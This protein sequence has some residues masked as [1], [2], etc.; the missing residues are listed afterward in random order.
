ML[1]LL[2]RNDFVKI[3]YI[4]NKQMADTYIWK[5][6]TLDR[7]ILN[8]TVYTIHYTVSASRTNPAEGESDYTADSYGTVGVTADPASKSFI[9]YEHLTEDIC[10]GWVKADLGSESVDNIEARISS[11][12]DE[13]I[14]PINAEGIPWATG[15][16]TE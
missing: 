15:T 14:S 6:A 5:V 2:V 7:E 16:T 13:Q 1:S 9:P 3:N 12:L 10:I 4:D 8:G 11:N